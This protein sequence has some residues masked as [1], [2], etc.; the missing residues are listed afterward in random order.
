[1]FRVDKTELVIKE[2]KKFDLTSIEDLIEGTTVSTR[3][4]PHTDHR[5]R[6]ELPEHA[7]RF[8][9]LS[10]EY[11]HKDGRTSFPL[12]FINWKPQAETALMTLHAS[13]SLDF[14]TAVRSCI[15]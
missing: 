10:Y 7:P 12:I 1:M 3:N 6:V 2:V 9:I 11:H 4:D 14:Q 8:I 13:A 5:I 15:Y